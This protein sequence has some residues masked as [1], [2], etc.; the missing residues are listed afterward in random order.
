MAV[1]ILLGV[2]SYAQSQCV[3]GVCAVP[4]RGA[5]VIVAPVRTVVR[6]AV[7][8]PVRVVQAVAP[9]RIYAQ[10]MQASGGCGGVA[11]VGRQRVVQRNYV[12][13]RLRR[14]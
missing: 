11:V 9:M 10:P 2:Q 1:A 12:F 4:N 13:P 8:A 6:A 3:N 5:A 14:R 7:V